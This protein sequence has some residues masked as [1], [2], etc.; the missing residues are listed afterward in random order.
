[1]SRHVFSTIVHWLG[2]G[3]EFGS[4]FGGVQRDNCTGGGPSI[5]E[6]RRDFRAMYNTRARILG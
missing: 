4:Y 3:S 2:A 1:M 6:S 5:E